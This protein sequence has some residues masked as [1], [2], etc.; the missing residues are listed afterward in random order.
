MRRSYLL[1]LAGERLTGEVME[2]YTNENIE[3]GHIQEDDA[4][5]LYAFVS[6]ELLTQVGFIRNG[7]K[8]CSP[9]SL[10]G[11]NGVLEV[12]CALAHILI[13]KLLRGD[14]PPEHIP[15]TQGQL[16]VCEREWVDIAIYSPKLPLFKKRAYRDVKEIARISREVDAFNDELAE[17]V[18]K[19]RRYTGE[20]PQDLKR[21]LQD[22]I[23]A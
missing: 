15:Q 1:K 8:G 14:F 19:V 16:W 22:S 12:K 4:R 10:V 20:P 5:R 3:R 23:G 21:A 18:E 17:T 6:D 9:D 2:S 7:E 11:E 13:D